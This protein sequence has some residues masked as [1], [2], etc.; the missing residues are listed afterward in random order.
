MAESTCT[1]RSAGSTEG[2]I[3]NIALQNTTS[4]ILSQ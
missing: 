3:T 1:C 4:C 2:K